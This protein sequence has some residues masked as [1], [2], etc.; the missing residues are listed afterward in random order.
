MTDE[1][2]DYTRL[3]IGWTDETPA[4]SPDDG[5]VVGHARE[6]GDA[7]VDEHGQRLGVRDRTV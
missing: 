3:D 1:R 6:D 4:P 7:D 5:S 2:E